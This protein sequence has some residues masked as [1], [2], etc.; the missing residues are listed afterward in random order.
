MFTNLSPFIVA[1]TAAVVIAVI[2]GNLML[3]DIGVRGHYSRWPLYAAVAALGFE[4]M[5]CL[6]AASD[7][8]TEQWTEG[9]VVGIDSVH[10]RIAIELCAIGALN[11]VASFLFLLRRW[12]LAW[13]LAIGMQ[14][15][16][17][18]LAEIE[19]LAIDPNAPGWTTFSR[20][21]LVTLLLLLVSRVAQGR[22]KSPVDRNREWSAPH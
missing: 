12:G 21:P 16:T 13:W 3:F 20:F 1:A 22:L 7:E 19:A 11:L 9:S 2:L 15:A 5:A 18:A 6:F 10:A 14:V 4:A 8:W 17:F